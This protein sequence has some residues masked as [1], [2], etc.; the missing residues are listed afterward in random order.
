MSTLD[1]IALSTNGRLS[2]S[3]PSMGS[4]VLGYC[5]ALPLFVRAVFPMARDKS[6]ITLASSFTD[7]QILATYLVAAV[8]ALKVC[9]A[10]NPLKHTNAASAAPMFMLFVAACLASSFGSRFPL[11]SIWRCF[12][13]LLLSVWAVAMIRDSSAAEDPSKAIRAFY[14]ISVAILAAVFVGL[15]IN[16]SGAWAV[17]G[18]IARLTGTT[19]YSINP[20]D[21]GAIAAVIAVGCYVRTVEHGS[22][23]YVV[24]TALFLIV[25]YLSHSRGSYIALAVGFTAATVMLGRLVDRRMIVFLMSLFS[26]LSVGAVVLVSHEVREFFVLLMT[27]GHETEN[28]ESLGGR[29]QL[30]EFGLKIF[31]QHPYLGTGYGTYP[32]GLE[33][34]HFHNVFIELLVT[35]GLAGTVSYAAF[36][37]A[38]AAATRKSIGRTNPKVATERII[39]ADLVTIPA[40]IIAANGA[41]AGA[42]YYSWD[43]LGLMSVAVTA[44]LLMRR[45]GTVSN[46]RVV[47][48]QFSNLLR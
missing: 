20:N 1:R 23:K 15:V 6:H 46:Q 4:V 40:V 9:T 17:E 27:R 30:W 28:L 31:G 45:R 34:G 25:C 13:V 2:E 37:V 44:G 47:Q 48:R 42:A 35:T 7:P 43:L 11:F 41:T 21:I 12:E 16:P 19:G 32:K 36:L 38:L 39:A 3:P 8:V 33:G 18:D 10:N 26:V 14:T 22:L 5:I 24:A 29:L